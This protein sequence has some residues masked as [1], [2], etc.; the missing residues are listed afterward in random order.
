MCSACDVLLKKKQKIPLLF[1]TKSQIL[2]CFCTKNITKETCVVFLLPTRCC[3]M[4]PA[5]PAVHAELAH[6]SYTNTLERLSKM[7]IFTIAFLF[8]T[9][10]N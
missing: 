5:L 10:M 7:T 6:F 2:F 8:A 3:L 9:K 1:C 4:I